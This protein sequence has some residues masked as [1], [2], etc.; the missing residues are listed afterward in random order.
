MLLLL[1]LLIAALTESLVAYLVVLVSGVAVVGVG[2]MW[3]AAFA[4]PFPMDA[5]WT[6]DEPYSLDTFD[7]TRMWVSMAMTLGAP[8]V[9]LA[10]RRRRAAIVV[11]VVL[12]A[13][14]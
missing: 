4:V 8:L 14:A 6:G 7:A 13:T 11:F 2:L 1:L 10:R 5:L 12:L 9:L 3:Q